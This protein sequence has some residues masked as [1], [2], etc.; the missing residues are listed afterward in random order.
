MVEDE[1]THILEYKAP[2]HG[3]VSR[4]GITIYR[5]KDGRDVVVAT[6]LGFGSG[7]SVTNGAELIASEVVRRFGVRPW[8]SVFV[9]HYPA[10]KGR[11][12]D[13]FDFVDFASWEG[14]NASG[15]SWR[16]GSWEAVEKIIK[17]E[18]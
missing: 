10:G 11:N 5:A 2:W 15:V 4:C 12:R 17:G 8:A 14:A 16:P 13:T 1:A 3:F 6:D 9:E 7:L 18:A